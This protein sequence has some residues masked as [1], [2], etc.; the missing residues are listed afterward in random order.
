M[1]KILAVGV[2]TGVVVYTFF[3]SLSKKV[4]NRLDSGST[5]AQPVLH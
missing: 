4:D 1:K 5:K 3:R 2:V